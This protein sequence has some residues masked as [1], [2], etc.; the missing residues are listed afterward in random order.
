MVGFHAELTKL[1]LGGYEKIHILRLLFG[2]SDRSTFSRRK[3][4]SVMSVFK[5][6][7]ASG[8]SFHVFWNAVKRFDRTI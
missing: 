2:R 3:K 5:V 8:I 1:K 4:D 7:I 6:E